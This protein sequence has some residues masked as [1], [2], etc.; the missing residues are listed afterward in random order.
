MTSQCRSRSLER[1]ST[2]FSMSKQKF[3]MS[4]H[5]FLMLKQEFG[6]SKQ[7]SR[8]LKHDFLMSKQAFPMSKQNFRIFK[9]KMECPRRSLSIAEE[10][11]GLATVAGPVRSLRE[12][13]CVQITAAVIRSSRRAGASTQFV[14]WLRAPEWRRSGPTWFC[15]STRSGGE[16]RAKTSFAS[17]RL[18]VRPI[19]D[20]R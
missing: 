16:A 18:R 1:R 19:T 8:M 13:P 10:T 2:V 9:Q 15:C 7:K 17:S 4:R 14:N 6:M 3:R 12:T 11:E 5:D 20:A